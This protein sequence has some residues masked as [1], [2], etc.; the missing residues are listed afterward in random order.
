VSA[1]VGWIAP[2]LVWAATTWGAREILR[3]LGL[4]RCRAGDWGTAFGLGFTLYTGLVY[5]GAAAGVRIAAPLMIGAAGLVFVVGHLL[6][7]RAPRRAAA[8]EPPAPWSPPERAVALLLTVSA[9]FMIINALYFPVTAMDAHSYDGRARFLVHDGRL[10]LAL[11]HWPGYVWSGNSN[12][13]YP[14]LFNL[15]LATAYAFGGWQSKMVTALFSLAWPL[16][17][18]GVLRPRLPR[19]AALMWTLAAVLT[20]E[21]FSHASYAL[22]NVPA[23]ALI[24]GAAAAWF[25]F[26]E[27]GNR[28][29]I[30]L[31]AAFAAGAA[32]VRPDA[33]VPHA[34]LGATALGFALADPRRRSEL[35]RWIVP[36]IAAGGAPLATWGTWTLYLRFVV[37]VTHLSPISSGD[38][39][40]P[41]I[42]IG[43]LPRLLP[44]FDTYGAVFWLWAAS[45][46]LLVLRGRTRAALFHHA[47]AVLVLCG[48]LALFA[49]IDRSYGGGVA[50]V[51]N[52]SFKRAVF[53]MIPLAVIGAALS[54]PWVWMAG[55]GRGWLHGG[56][57]RPRMRPARG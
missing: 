49:G 38:T 14:P 53:Y 47:A 29:W 2:A 3:G 51:V 34:A 54:P 9:A 55:V 8:P 31:A 37:G 25:R 15:G 12:M 50:D 16:M 6:G 7:R 36:M 19:F 42:M 39:I 1:A 28:A 45:L 23:M 46:P 10:D 20:P 52:S 32:G 4:I 33:L 35:R 21:V 30:G 56:A 11:Y 24:L 27:E 17:L 18:F 13:T 44:N 5:A 22:L 43:V 26:L 57:P 41:G 48:L 40:G